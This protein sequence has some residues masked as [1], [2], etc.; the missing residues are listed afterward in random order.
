[1][2]ICELEGC[3]NKHFGR[4]L[5]SKHY[6]RQLRHG[7][8]NTTAYIRDDGGDTKLCIVCKIEKSKE[9]FSPKGNHYNSWCKE[10]H[11]IYQRESLKNKDTRDKKYN[12]SRNSFY[13]KKYGITIQQYEELLENQ[14]YVC[15]IC[16]KEDVGGKRLAV[17]HCH[18]TGLVRGLLCGS[19]NKALGGFN[20]D[21]ALLNNAINYLSSI[22]NISYLSE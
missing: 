14:N 10:C 21:T 9:Y 5:C 2:R 4:G 17:D 7:D 13:K 19:C 22:T 11:N 16:E 3:N 1:M 15:K 18:N 8:V 20:D 12:S 6:T